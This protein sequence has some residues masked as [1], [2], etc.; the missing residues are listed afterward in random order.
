[1]FMSANRAAARKIFCLFRHSRAP[2]LRHERIFIEVLHGVFLALKFKKA[3][4]LF[5]CDLKQVDL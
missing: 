2:I 1:M 4:D 3:V 5:V